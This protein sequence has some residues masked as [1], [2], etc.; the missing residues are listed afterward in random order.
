MGGYNGTPIG[1]AQGGTTMKREL[2]LEVDGEEIT[3]T[4][5]REG[6]SIRVERDGASY[7][8]RIVA[9]SI[10]GLKSGASKPTGAGSVALSGAPNAPSPGTIAPVS[11]PPAS[12]PTAAL[13]S[14]TVVAPMTGV[15]D[16]VSVEVGAAV[17]EG[18]TVVVLEA[19]KMYIDVVAPSNGTVQTIAVHAG[20]SVKEGDT[21]IT[22]E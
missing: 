2:I 8:V 17:A 9:E 15:I 11:R 3:V 21:L 10:V 16:A 6:E 19:M 4:A 1:G 13:A 22:I 7:S 5:M 14:G 18:E 12:R 20:D